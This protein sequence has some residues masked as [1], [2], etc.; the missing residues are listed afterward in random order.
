MSVNGLNH[1]GGKRLVRPGEMKMLAGVCAGM[2]A[3]LGWRVSAVRILFVLFSLLTGILPGVLV[4]TVLV[5]IIPK[6]TEYDWYDYRDDASGK[7]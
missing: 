4:Y 5:F 1:G 2:A 7:S 3:R 6:E